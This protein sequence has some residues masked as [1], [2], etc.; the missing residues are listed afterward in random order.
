MSK[1][2]Y[3]ARLEWDS[4]IF[5][6]CLIFN[7]ASSQETKSSSSYSTALPETNSDYFKETQRLKNRRTSTEYG[8]L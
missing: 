3:H 6:K 4:Y 2:P 5:D 7:T 8:G 1:L